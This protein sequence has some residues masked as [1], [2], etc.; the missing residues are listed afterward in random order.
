MHCQY[1]GGKNHVVDYIQN[2]D[3]PCNYH[4]FDKKLEKI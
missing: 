3:F 4:L 1:K 2:G